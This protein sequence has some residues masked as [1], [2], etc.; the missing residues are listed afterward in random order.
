MKNYGLLGKLTKH[1]SI[2]RFLQKKSRHVHLSERSSLCLVPRPSRGTIPVA[3]R[4]RMRKGGCVCQK[5]NY[6]ERCTKVKDL[7]CESCINTFSKILPATQIFV[8]RPNPSANIYV[9]AIV[10]RINLAIY[11]WE[12]SRRSVL[13]SSGNLFILTFQSPSLW[14]IY[15]NLLRRKYEFFRRAKLSFVYRHRWHHST[16]LFISFAN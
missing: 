10:G 11:R 7:S 12:N 15:G 8:R 6:C 13:L 9:S 2:F 14:K 16:F 5:R 1:V 3:K 4:N